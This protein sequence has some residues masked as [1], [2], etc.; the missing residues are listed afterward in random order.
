VEPISDQGTS[1]SSSFPDVNFI[2]VKDPLLSV[3][4]FFKIESNV[5]VFMH[6]LCFLYFL[7]SFHTFVISEWNILLNDTISV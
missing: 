1:P 3:S 2:D 4:S 5:S 7:F 6:S